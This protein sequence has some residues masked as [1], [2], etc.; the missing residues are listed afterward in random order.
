MMIDNEAALRLLEGIVRQIGED[1]RLLWYIKTKLNGGNWL[2][3]SK[4][5]HVRYDSD[6]TMVEIP[7]YKVETGKDKKLKTINDELAEMETYLRENVITGAM[8]DYIITNLRAS[9]DTEKVID[10]MDGLLVLK[11]KADRL[12]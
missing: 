1:Y 8:S 5:P 12:A 10:K 3:V 6:T 9:C 7:G 2:M 11:S 4:L